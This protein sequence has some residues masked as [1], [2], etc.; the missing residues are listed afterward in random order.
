MCLCGVGVGVDCMNVCHRTCAIGSLRYFPFHFVSLL[1]WICFIFV[2][3]P[4][5]YSK[6]LHYVTFLFNI[7]AGTFATA[8]FLSD[9]TIRNVL[10]LWFCFFILFAVQL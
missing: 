7:T 3:F 6:S 8:T 1:V 4:S 10:L 5:F 2:Y 9:A